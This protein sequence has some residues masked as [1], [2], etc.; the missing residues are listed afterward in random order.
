V[1]LVE[2]SLQRVGVAVDVRQDRD[3]HIAQWT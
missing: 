2:H 3:A 1:H